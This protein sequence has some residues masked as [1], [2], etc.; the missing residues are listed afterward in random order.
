MQDQPS[1][2][3]WAEEPIRKLSR[4]EYERLREG[5]GKSREAAKEE[6][7]SSTTEE[8]TQPVAGPD[9]SANPIGEHQNQAPGQFTQ[10]AAPEQQR[11]WEDR[12]KEVP[13]PHSEARAGLAA[14]YGLF[15]RPVVLLPIPS[16]RKEPN[17]VDWQQINFERTQTEDYQEILLKAFEA[18]NVGVS[19]GRKSGGLFTINVNDQ[20]AV[21]ELVQDFPWLEDTTRSWAQRGCQFWLLLEE[22]DY[23]KA[24]IVL[25]KRDGKVVGELRLGGDKGNQSVIDG[26]HKCGVRYQRNGKVSKEVGWS[27]LDDL[28]HWGGYQSKLEQ[29]AQIQFE[30]EQKLRERY[31]LLRPKKLT[32]ASRKL[33]RELIRGILYQSRRML[34]TGASKSRKSWMLQQVAYSISNGIKFLDRF[35]TTQSPVLYVNFELLEAGL[36]LRFDAMQR[37]LGGNQ[38]NII[39]ISVSDYLDMLGDNFSQYLALCAREFARKAVILDPMWRIMGSFDENK[40]SEV[41]LALAPLVR[42][43]REAQ[44]SMIGAHHHAKGSPVGKEAIDRSSGAGAWHRDPAVIW[45]M[46]P[47][48]SPE[49]FTINVVTSDFAPIEPFVV[50]FAHPL[51]TIDKD[52][53]PS[54]LRA[55]PRPKEEEKVDEKVEKM[56]AVLRGADRKGGLD[57]TE[58]SNAAGL[59]EATFSRKLKELIRPG[60]PA[61]KSAENGKYQLTARYLNEWA[62]KMEEC[63]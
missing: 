49:C 51:F 6:A 28:M 12:T 16:G 7:A 4:E 36:A 19:L 54:D 59:P 37:K 25:L 63:D 23:P 62:S 5:V 38:D 42:F 2:D 40:N 35:P 24:D 45:T 22:G 46:T 47:H 30:A 39:V 8:Q 34:L 20:G 53:D 21:E 3:E 32:D 15:P 18:A 41:R 61:Y 33:P 31:Q 43:S 29:E 44:A 1:I 55:P 48:R 56:L 52:L 13:R 17:L 57:W 50:R 26:V 14:L 58:W 11:R 27:D 10:A 9:L 60:G